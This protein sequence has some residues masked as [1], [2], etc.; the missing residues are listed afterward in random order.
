MNIT[1][2]TTSFPR[3]KGDFAG[4][5][6]HRWAHGFY[7]NGNKIC[8]IAPDDKEVI[9]D[10]DNAT[11]H[12]SRFRYFWPFKFQSFA[13]GAGVFS[14]IQQ[15]PL[16]ILQA[17]FFMLAFFLRA[18]KNAKRTDLF[19]SFWLPG[20]C[21]GVAVKWFTGKPVV[22]RLS[23]SDLLLIQSP[24]T[25]FFIKLILKHTRAVV[26]QDKTFYSALVQLGVAE[27][28]I[29]CIPNGLD[30]ELFQPYPKQKAR[31]KLG[32]NQDEKYILAVGRL[33]KSKGHANLI[34]AFKQLLTNHSNL[35]LIIVGEGEE[36]QSLLDLAVKEG[37]ADKTTLAGFQEHTS[38]PWWLNA[39][40]VFVLPSHLEGTPNILL[41]AMACGLPVIATDV[42]G[43]A[44][45]ITNE[46]NGLL[47][48]PDSRIEIEMALHRVLNDPV[49]KKNMEQ[50]ALATI[51][52]K[53]TNWDQQALKLEHHI[54]EKL[55]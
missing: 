1:I 19:F 6:A 20:A 49:L 10:K 38:I 40:D 35:R 29:I 42:G 22:A 48:Q 21:V 15:N 43:V 28:K 31:K 7:N 11:L 47:I 36:K 18:L 4:A 23:G 27:E 53:F 17:P 34:L 3:F 25:S 24:A 45:I 41:E 50:A 12:I 2:L 8:V 26:C 52:R 30:N 13:Y 46:Q 16:R 9:S 32:L 55:N 39:A 54:I 14:R 33:S 37:V 5:F 51:S 44:E